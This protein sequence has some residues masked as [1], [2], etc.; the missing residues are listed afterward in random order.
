MWTYLVTPAAVAVLVLGVLWKARRDIG[1]EEVALH[2]V[3]RR[4]INALVE[5]ETVRV[6]GVPEVA[7]AE[8]LRGPYSGKPCIAFTAR[9]SARVDRGQYNDYMDHTVPQESLPFEIRDD[10]G[11]VSLGTEHVRLDLEPVLFDKPKAFGASMIAREAT[12]GVSYYEHALQPGD[13][14]AAIGRVERGTDGK[15]RIVGTAKAPLVISNREGA[16]V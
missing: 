16:F 15:L 11:I 1:R 8:L 14:V 7:Q 9:T 6:V 3:A 12:G 10:S 2:K 13:R 5:G 4:A